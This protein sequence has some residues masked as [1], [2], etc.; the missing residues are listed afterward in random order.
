MA[1]CASFGQPPDMRPGPTRDLSE[2]RPSQR[3][4]RHRVVEKMRAGILWNVF[5]L[6]H[7]SCLS[8]AS[9]FRSKR[10]AKPHADFSI[11]ASRMRSSG[12]MTAGASSRPATCHC[13]SGG[14][15]VRGPSAP[16]LSQRIRSVCVGVSPVAS[17]RLRPTQRGG[18]PTFWRWLR[19]CYLASALHRFAGILG[20]G[21][22]SLW[23]L[24]NSFQLGLLEGIDSRVASLT[25]D[26]VPPDDNSASK[27][28][29]TAI[30]ASDEKW[31]T[32]PTL[33]IC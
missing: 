33:V 10:S 15:S 9:E 17:H 29:L 31:T 3:R 14:G 27:L 4:A 23:H 11:F 21:R 8:S 6:D 32:G 1:H 30:R 5:R 18:L 7:L 12:V 24:M 25:A 22:F 13:S 19:D 26:G 2:S 28:P 16:P 20:S